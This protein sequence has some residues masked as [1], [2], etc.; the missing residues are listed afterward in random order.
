[1]KNTKKI[2]LS[3]DTIAEDDLVGL[4]NWLLTN[5]RL[6][7]G[8]LTEEF[9]KIYAEWVGTKYSVFVNS[10]SSALLIMFAGLIQAGMLYK[11]AKV[12][13]PNV[14][15]STDASSVMNTGLVPIFCDCNL[16]DL[17]VDLG[18]LEKI[19]IK[20]KPAALLL[21]E[22]LGLVPDMPKIKALCELHGVILLEDT[23]ESMGS[24]YGNDM[25]GSFGFASVFSTYFGHHISTIE[26]GF[27]C[28]NDDKFYNI[29]KSLRSHGWDRDL[30]DGAR[31]ELRENFDIDDFK[32]RYTFYYPSFNLRSTDLQAFI[33]LG[34]MKKMD[35]IHAVREVNFK[36]FLFEL[37]L[38]NIWK[39]STNGF[40]SNFAYPIISKNKAEIVKK[41]EDNGVE[42]RPLICGDM[43][44]QPYIINN[45][46]HKI[47]PKRNATM[48]DQYGFYV[49]N[50]PAVTGDD[51]KMMCDIIKELH[52]E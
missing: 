8:D 13:V 41:L 28:T 30:Q 34:Q 22:V 9:E 27:V 46:G 49:P 47:N 39:P 11:G 7:K 5:P 42:C 35:H 12:V 25:L 52:N 32:A 6:T 21:V 37:S 18:E 45:Y 48:V 19:F 10:G 29:L 44:T 16:E 51:I 3:E 4:S 2:R 20:D 40:C 38:V 23:C 1:M 17:S 31:E 24:K 33:G 15:W 43:E 14:S 26:G 50:H 36:R